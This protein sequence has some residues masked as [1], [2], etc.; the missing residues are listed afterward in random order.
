MHHI[1]QDQ[2]AHAE[3]RRAAYHEV[4]HKVIY[5][6]FGGAGDAVVWKNQSGR[7]DEVA[8]CGQ[9]RPRTCVE[10]M[11]AALSGLGVPNLPENWRTLYGIAGVVAEQIL[12]GETDVECIAGAL[13]LMVWFDEVST[14][15]MASIGVTD[16]DQFEVDMD[17]VMQCSQLL[18]EHWS[19]IEREAEFLVA[20][21]TVEA[22]E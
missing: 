18:R 5:E 6:Y 21:A 14:S 20:D 17:D 8:W 1:T 7:I 19:L 3:L 11:N 15:D 10:Q 16:I 12:H 22:V 9:F 13:Q 4:G 2:T